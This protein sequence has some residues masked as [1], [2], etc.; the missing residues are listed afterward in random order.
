MIVVGD[1][2]IMRERVE[3]KK[4]VPRNN[5][6]RHCLRFTVLLYLLPAECS[7]LAHHPLT[8]HRS[9][10]FLDGGCM[11][12]VSSLVFHNVFACMPALPVVIADETSFSSLLMP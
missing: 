3:F 10:C 1:I 9:V 7:M 12:L 8:E 4:R 5:S 6:H 2:S 11:C